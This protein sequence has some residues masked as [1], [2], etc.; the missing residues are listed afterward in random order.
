MLCPWCLSE[1]SARRDRNVFFCPEC[2][3]PVSFDLNG[4]F[5]RVVRAR[6]LYV[7]D[8]P[9]YTPHPNHTNHTNHKHKQLTWGDLDERQHE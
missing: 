8:H 7:Y 1:I 4:D 2:N 3:K 9:T 6:E 5:V